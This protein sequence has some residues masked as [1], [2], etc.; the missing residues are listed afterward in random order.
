MYQVSAEYAAR[1][2]SDDRQFTARLTMLGGSSAVLTGT[3]I[4]NVTLDEI[5]NSSD[6]LTLGCACSNKLTVSLINPPRDIDYNNASFVAE[7]GLLIEDRPITYEWIKLGTFYVTDPETNN[8]FQ[9]LKLTA[10]DG[11]TKMTGKYIP[12]AT[13]NTTIQAVYNDLKTQLMAECGITLKDRTL[14]SYSMTLPNLDITYTQAI[15]YVA[16][17]LGGFARFDRNGELEIVTYEDN[18]LTISRSLQYMGGFT[19]TTD[20]SLTVTSL[21]TGTSDKTIVRG[22][23]ANGSAI[24]FENPYITDAMADDI[25]GTWEGFMYTPCTV[26]WRGN[27]AVQAGDII[28]VLD[29]DL[30]PHVVPIMSQTV[31]VGGGC[32]ATIECKGIN[33]TKSEFSTRFESTAQKLERY[34]T[35][36]ERAIL[37]ATNAITG[38]SGGYVILNDTN[39]DGRPDEILIM[40]AESITAATKVW[41]WN[42]EGL[43]F[44]SNPAGNAYLGPYRTAI[45]AAGQINADFITV[46]TL[47]AE[48]LAVENFDADDPTLI[49]DYIRF[50]NGSMS[51]GKGNSA[52]TLKL[53]HNQ[54]A[55]YR[56]DTRIAY[57]GTN[58]F[59]IENL[60]DG[61]I[62]FQNFGFIPR[63]S[64]NLS[65]TLL[66]S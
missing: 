19:R 9:N 5:V 33:E 57:F 55:F 3:T 36:L 6:A 60:T 45:T 7:V 13:E 48:R 59:E 23:G 28:T 47:S 53:E 25:W 38:N 34:Y 44:A 14:P 1:I 30:I 27:P 22:S 43:G 39:D 18:L 31:K 52:I 17:C 21:S 42:K 64:G 54:V 37:D 35:T 49:T 10:Y 66:N 15:A 2:T 11:F 56:G 62:R 26:K 63:E 16:G 41:R 32:N 58:S 46:G 4:Q 51:F 12:T 8:D 40:D 20:K 65:F 29:K 24:S 61:K 50:E